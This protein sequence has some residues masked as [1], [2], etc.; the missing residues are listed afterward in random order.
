MKKDGEY[1]KEATKD[2]EKKIGCYQKQITISK[3]A[4]IKNFHKN[5]R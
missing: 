2:G 5:S 3:I 1:I 4:Q